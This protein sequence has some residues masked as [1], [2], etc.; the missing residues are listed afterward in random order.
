MP[1]TIVLILEYYGWAGLAVA[2]IFLLYGIDRVVPSARGV[3]LFRPLVAP[4]VVLIWPLVLWR[5]WL[6]AKDEKGA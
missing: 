3:F 6:L 1:E 4:G 2:V 5:W